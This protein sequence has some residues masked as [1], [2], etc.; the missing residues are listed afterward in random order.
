MS[1]KERGRKVLLEQVLGGKCTLSSAALQMGISYRQCLRVRDRYS[2]EGD[3]G[4]VHCGR[5]RASSRSRPCEFRA[6]V[7]MLCRERFEGLGPTL[8]AEKLL[9]HG[10]ELDHETLR[11][12]L[13]A[14]GQWKKSRKRGP[15]R[16][17]RERRKRF[18]ELVQ[19]DGSHHRWF[20]KE[21][22]KACLMNLVDDATGASMSLMAE[23]ETTEA[24]MR[25]LW[26]WVERHGVPQALYLDKKSV[27][28]ALRPPTLEEQLR[29]E[30]PLTHFGVACK[31]LGIAL[32]T[33]HSPQAKGRVERKHALYQDRL[34]HELRL[35]GIHTIEGANALLREGFED[36]LNAKFA[37]PPMDS[38]D[39]HRRPNKHTD[40]RN[41][42]CFD[43]L[44]TIANDYTVRHNN[45][46]LQILKLNH[47]CP[48]PRQKITVRT[49]LCGAIHLYYNRKQLQFTVL[50]NPPQQT[51][52][53]KPAPLKLPKATSAPPHN[54][55]WKKSLLHP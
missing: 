8:M 24:A 37:R 41:V 32:I 1:A 23:E 3:A 18:G 19:L 9:E 14:D 20:G 6:Q 5:G 53:R 51:Q 25:A 42:F 28:L 31:K 7:L 15:H 43:E 12:W 48:K 2:A 34:Y 13:I 55:P 21:H 52:T 30:E 16:T 54:H 4:L 47:P 45:R 46:Y 10:F 27:Y 40:L 29:G 39:A 26:Q 44:R 17:Q 49:W 22:P 35:K 33:A 11:R 50:D 38:T 36:N